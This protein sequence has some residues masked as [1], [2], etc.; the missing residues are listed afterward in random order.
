MPWATFFLTQSVVLLAKLVLT[1]RTSEWDQQEYAQPQQIYAQ[2]QQEYAQPQQNYAQPQQEYSQPQN[3][4]Q[5]QQEYSQPQNYAQP[6]QEYSQPQPTYDA[7]ND[8]PTPANNGT[9]G[10]SH[11]KSSWVLQRRW[12]G[13]V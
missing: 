5:P 4:A 2:P 9:T 6:R 7:W 12:D 8:T 13:W 11:S 3:Y 10:Y 1:L